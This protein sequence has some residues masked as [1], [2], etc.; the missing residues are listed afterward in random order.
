MLNHIVKSPCLNTEAVLLHRPLDLT[1]DTWLNKLNQVQC[2][3]A[4]QTL[5][6]GAFS[7]AVGSSA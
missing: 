4:V 2:R 3:L 6:L 5:C 1:L 7:I